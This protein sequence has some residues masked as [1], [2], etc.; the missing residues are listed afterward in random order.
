MSELKLLAL[1]EDDLKVISACMQDAVFKIGDMSFEARAGQFTLVAN[2]FV[3]EEETKKRKTHERRRAALV[4]K[5]VSA[6]RSIGFSRKDRDGVLSLLAIRYER[7]GEGPEGWIELTLAGGGSI[8]LQV[9]VLE[10]QLADIGGAW[11]TAHKPFHPEA[12]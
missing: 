3:W 9:E 12:G 2:R 6:V 1:D 11:E 7:D 5:R 4:F 8:M 10:A